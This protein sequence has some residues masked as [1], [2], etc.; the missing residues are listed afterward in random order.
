MPIVIAI[1]ECGGSG[2]ASRLTPENMTPQ[3]GASV[4][5]IMR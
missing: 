1:A 5:S 3:K 4:G 2:K